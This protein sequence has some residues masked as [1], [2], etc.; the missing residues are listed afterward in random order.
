MHVSTNIFLPWHVPSYLAVKEYSKYVIIV[1][2]T[3]IIIS[4]YPK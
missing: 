2:Y 3:Q 1:G 4:K